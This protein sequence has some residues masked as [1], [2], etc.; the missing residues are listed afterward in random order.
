MTGPGGAAKSNPEHAR[1]IHAAAVYCRG[2]GTAHEDSRVSGVSTVSRS[3]SLTE[4][5]QVVC[6]ASRAAGLV[7]H[8]RL[9]WLSRRLLSRLRVSGLQNLTQLRNPGLHT[10]EMTLQH[11][12]QP[13]ELVRGE[14]KNLHGLTRLSSVRPIPRAIRR[15]WISHQSWSTQ[16]NGFHTEAWH[17]GGN[18]NC[19][20]PV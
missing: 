19:A 14:I 5:A 1:A 2:L 16:R 7:G 4:C 9:W 6:R 20:T 18:T 8:G 15:R 10:I 11:T 3:L 17:R 13:P 12:R